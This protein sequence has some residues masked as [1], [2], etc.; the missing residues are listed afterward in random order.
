MCCLFNWLLNNLYSVI[1][2]YDFFKNLFIFIFIFIF[3]LG[4]GG[5]FLDV[6]AREANIMMAISTCV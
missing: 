1:H 6:Q 4:G 5:L 2:E 3:F